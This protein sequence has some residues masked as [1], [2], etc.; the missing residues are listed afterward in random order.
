MRALKVLLVV[1]LGGWAL[2][3]V[4]VF[5]WFRERYGRGGPMPFRRAWI[6]VNPLRRWYHPVRPTLEEFRLKAGDTVLELGPGPGY[7]T[8]EASRMVGPQGRLLCVDVQP[9]MLSML[10]QRL[11]EQGAVNAHPLVGDA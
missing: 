8:V 6:L 4:Y 1:L 5:V 7:F 2:L 9:P 10:R 11:E 3:S